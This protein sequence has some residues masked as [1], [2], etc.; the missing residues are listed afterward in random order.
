[1]RTGTT[2]LRAGLLA[3]ALGAALLAPAHADTLEAAEA[4]L[5]ASPDG[6]DGAAGTESDPTTLVSAIDRVSSGGVVHLLGGTYDLDE[7]VYIPLGADGSSSAPTRLF[8]ASGQTPVLDFSAQ[9]EDSANR[10]LALEASHWHIRGITVQN[11]GDNGIFVSGSD[12]VVEGVVTRFNSDTGLQ[13]SRRAS[14]TPDDEWPA[15]NLVVSSV[16]HDNV[17]SDGEDADGFAAKLTSGPGNV[18]RYTV[19]HNNIDDGWDLYTKSDTGAIGEVTVEYSLALENGTLSDGSQA[20]DGDRNGFKL[21][22]EDIAVDHTVR[23]NI[24]YDNGKH[25]FTYN[26]NLGTQEITDNI[27]IGSE[28]RNFNFDGGS[29]VFRGNTSCDSGSNDRVIGDAD[30][31][32][33]FWSG[34]NGSRCADLTGD[35][36]W[37]FDGDGVLVVTIGGTPVLP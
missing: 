15:N 25:G 10:G 4:E 7:T 16:S 32:N 33:Q 29:S 34:S 1:M 5:Y 23:G 26:R 13:I 18:F 3:G 36:E 11:A 2:A 17:D 20:G 12:N 37:S 28:E 19:A 31:S 8:A 9:S 14:D 24:A 30:G 6:S 21:G 27:S 35:L 22:G